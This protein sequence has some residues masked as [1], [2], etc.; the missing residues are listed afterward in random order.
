MKSR[1]RKRTEEIVM[2]YPSK[3]EAAKEESGEEQVTKES[4]CRR[5]V[6]RP[7]VPFEKK[8]TDVDATEFRES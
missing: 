6:A 2:E 7:C 8:R 4:L 3:E 5:A 1:Q